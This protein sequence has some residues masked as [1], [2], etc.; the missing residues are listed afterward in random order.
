MAY[1]PVYLYLYTTPITVASDLVHAFASPFNW[2][3]ENTFEIFVT[4]DGCLKRGYKAST[5]TTDI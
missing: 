2:M 3:K 4:F 5:N 1:P